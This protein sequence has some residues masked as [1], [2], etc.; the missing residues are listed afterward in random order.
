MEV[1]GIS[2]E[3][4]DNKL[5]EQELQTYN[6]TILPYVGNEK[7]GAEVKSLITSV[8]SMNSTHTNESG[9]FIALEISVENY[10]NTIGD[11]SFTDNNEAYVNEKETKMEEARELISVEKKYNI[12]VKYDTL[13]KINVV[14]IKET[15]STNTENTI[16]NDI[17][18]NNTVQNTVQQN[19]TMQNNVLQNN[20]GNTTNN[21]ENNNTSTNTSEEIIKA[22]IQKA[23]NA[24]VSLY[25]N[26][27]NIA[28]L[29]VQ[30]INSQNKVIQESLPAGYKIEN[31]T[32]IGTVV[33]FKLT[34][35]SNTYSV[36][37]NPA[38]KAVILI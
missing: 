30:D 29:L 16:T 31:A 36:T 21:N 25:S 12:D 38:T 5:S 37:Y 20:T 10:T 9:S 22:N 6:Q 13:G 35:N 33:R 14:I 32:T 17:A 27:S 19:N 34:V 2:N 7:N 26:S 18:S 15:N 28:T 8:I 24:R 1:I 4:N 3:V 23:L 11:A